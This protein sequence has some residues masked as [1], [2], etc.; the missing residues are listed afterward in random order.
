MKA[1][2]TDG[3]GTIS[4]IKG[5]PYATHRLAYEIEYG[6]IPDKLYV[7]HTCD[8]RACCNPAHLRAGTNIEN[9]QDMLNKRRGGKLT[10]EQIAEINET[11]ARLRIETNPVSR[12]QYYA[13]SRTPDIIALILQ[14]VPYRDIA[15]QL[16]CSVPHVTNTAK[17]RLY[18]P[19]RFTVEGLSDEQLFA[20]HKEATRIGVTVA[21]LARALIIDGINEIE[22]KANK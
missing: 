2:V 7:L 22:D 9:T 13:N 3:Y 6:S 5:I 8:N 11:A 20:I 4:L 17:R 16:N 10:H 12:P 21:E 15:K 1:R 18:G 19:R 14:G